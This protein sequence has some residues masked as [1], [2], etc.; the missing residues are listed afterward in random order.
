MFHNTK[1]KQIILVRHARAVEREEWTGADYDRPLTEEGEQSNQIVANYLRL[2]GV[3]P[4]QI[5]A[6][7]AAR[8]RMTAESIA[9]KFHNHTLTFNKA[10]YNE[11]IVWPRDAMKVHFDVV[12]KARHNSNI[13][14]IVGHNNDLSEF[15]SYLANEPVPSMKKWSVI[16]LSLPED[17]E[18]KNVKPGTLKF[19]YY[20]TPHFLRLE[21]L[22]K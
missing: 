8:T 2:I 4:D 18:W 13:L 19:I 12:R 16:V 9:K 17:T 22:D 20:L 10:L 6:S 1:K 7:P 3:K 15:A 21:S 5:V 14:M 11:D